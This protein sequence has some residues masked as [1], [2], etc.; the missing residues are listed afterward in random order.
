VEAVLATS[1]GRFD[2]L[3]GGLQPAQQQELVRLAERQQSVVAKAVPVLAIWGV[4]LA[5]EAQLNK[6]AA[7]VAH[8]L[9]ECRPN[10]LMFTGRR[11]VS[12]ADAAELLMR[13]VLASPVGFKPSTLVSGGADGVDAVA[14]RLTDPPVCPGL[15][16][17]G[18]YTP[19]P[20]ARADVD[21]K[22]NPRPV[23]LAGLE[24]GPSPLREAAAMEPMPAPGP[25]SAFAEFLAL[26][27][28]Q[29]EARDTHNAE[30]ADA[31]IAFLTNE[32]RPQHDGTKA[33]LNI[34]AEGRYTHHGN[35]GQWETDGSSCGVETLAEVETEKK[36]DGKPGPHVNVVGYKLMHAPPYG[37]QTD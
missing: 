3:P 34:F 30:Q 24:P 16:V 14:L 22:L 32:K 9:K 33:T 36:P 20:F 28:G 25:G 6:L 5:T 8:F 31:C 26:M 19:T 11:A 15:T 1:N 4:D 37:G 27:E 29:W 12:V 17:T 18:Q 7:V 2:A 23:A 21:G 10:R 13:G 35:T